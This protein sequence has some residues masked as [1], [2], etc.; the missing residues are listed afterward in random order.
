MIG[1]IP[2]AGQLPV[3]EEFFELFKTPWE[4]W[5]P[6]KSYDVVVVTADA[7]PDVEA[8]LMVIAGGAKTIDRR[9]GL[10]AD[11]RATGGHLAYGSRTLAIYGDLTTFESAGPAA[12]IATAG[13]EAA[14]LRLKTDGRVIVRLGYDLFAE[15]AILLSVGQPADLAH[16]PTLDTHI[17]VLRDSIIDAGL[18]LLEIPPVPAGFRFGVC[19]THDIDFTGI[20]AHLFDR[21]MFGFLYRATIGACVSFCGGRLSARRLLASWRAAAALPFVF[22]G[23]ARDFWSPFEWYLKV[24]KGLPATYFLIPFKRRAGEHVHGRRASQRATAYDI[25]DVTQWVPALVEAGCEVGVHGIDAWH[26]AAAGRAERA[27]IAQITKADEIGIRMHWLMTNARTWRTLEEAGF[28]YDATA[29]YNET[30][31]YR[32]GTTQVFCPPGAATLL[33]LPLHVQ[34]GALFYPRRL[35]LSEE[36]AWKRCLALID[37]AEQSGGMLTILWHDR[38][39]A[40][41]RFWGD[42]YVR[43]VDELKSRGAWFA[44][45]RQATRWFQRRRASRFEEVREVQGSAEVRVH[46]ADGEDGLPR[47]SASRMD[48]APVHRTTAA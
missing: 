44:T 9:H 18:P 27:R 13:G 46:L 42:F 43:L 29:G 8:R 35:H 3:V 12:P 34:D 39:H 17:M 2:Q 6:G 5:R 26:D 16:L 33:E 4:L 11:W 21:T 32:H 10:R 15:V 14:G 28:A 48:S 25:G 37:H 7:V 19:L 41:E 45:G 30:I 1:V 22:L 24:E 40:P 23:W 38:S 36:E 47:L 31:G 20:R